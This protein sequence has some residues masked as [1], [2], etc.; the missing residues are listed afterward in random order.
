M[1]KICRLTL[2]SRRWS[3]V[4]NN[5][6]PE[7]SLRLDTL[8][9]AVLD[10]EYAVRGEI[11]IR[12]Y[13]LQ[14][15]LEN[16]ASLP[17]SRLVYC[18]IGNPQALGQAPLTFHR[19]LLS[20]ITNP[21]S[22]AKVPEDVQKRARAYLNACPKFGAYTHS[23]G[24]DYMREQIAGAID[25]RDKVEKTNIE[26]LFITDGASMGVKTVLELLI[27][28]ST[29]GILIPIPQYPLYSASI[30]RLN[31]T[32]IGYE[33]DEDYDQRSG[34][35]I[36]MAEIEKKYTS[37]RGNV[38]AI[39]VINPGNPTGNVLSR[40]EMEEIVKFAQKHRCVILA[41]EV[42]QSNIYTDKEFISFRRV[43]HE[44]KS[45]VE[46]FSFMSISKGYY[47]ECGL[48]GGYLHATNIESDVLAQLYKL[49]SMTLCSNTLGQALVA[50]ILTPPESGDPS[51][52]LFEKEKNSILSS[53][54]RKAKLVEKRLNTIP[55]IDCMPVEGAMYAFV[56][57]HLPDAYIAK[58]KNCGK[59]PDSM[60]CMDM[61]EKTGVVTVPGSGFGQKAGSYHFRITILPDEESI[62]GVLD[63]FEKFHLE[64]CATY[65][66]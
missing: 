35:K 33:M 53:L 55:G 46:L 60:Y 42:Y 37:H 43:V 25:R 29:D 39:V 40:D 26:D 22:D 34:W 65:E 63:V 1:L 4:M 17:F 8:S 32:W 14:K 11:V 36:N 64:L 38:R 62:G 24:M 20:L 28:T 41:D 18:N 12:A 61:L 19:Q 2:T 47:G 48:R 5:S 3:H 9:K 66:K 31:G 16:G 7:K 27:G 57:V 44:M 52:D 51:Y 10:S 15:Q 13:E 30:V 59:A 58:A 21:G 56:R 54:K 50:S 45:P 49:F 23:K 6:A